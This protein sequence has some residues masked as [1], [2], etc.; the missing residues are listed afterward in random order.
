MRLRKEV[1]LRA[2]K[3]NWPI[4][5][6]MCE[7]LNGNILS[8]EEPEKGIAFGIAFQFRLA[9]ERLELPGTGERSWIT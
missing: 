2:N 7:V 6:C 1:A 9:H 4:S 5:D 8:A 3:R